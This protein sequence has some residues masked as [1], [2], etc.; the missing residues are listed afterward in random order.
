MRA[1]SVPR[2]HTHKHFHRTSSRLNKRWWNVNTVKNKGKRSFH[3]M[4]SGFICPTKGQTPLL[5]I[6]FWSG[7]SQ[8]LYNFFLVANGEMC[9]CVGGER[10]SCLIVVSS[11]NPGP[12]KWRTEDTEVE[13][14]FVYLLSPH[15]AAAASSRCTNTCRPSATPREKSILPRDNP[16]WCVP[17]KD[18][19]WSWL[20]CLDTSVSPPRP[21]TH[22]VSP[23][24]PKIYDFFS[25]PLCAHTLFSPLWS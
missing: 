24:L 19:L 22:S 13:G 25:S 7:V 17:V 12:R 8:A 6:F 11:E 16:T 23:C 10:Q 2:L 4:S 5:F 20:R 18:T 21:A 15:S 14:L 9:V 1:K 3:C